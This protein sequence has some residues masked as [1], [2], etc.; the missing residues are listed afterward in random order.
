MQR[1]RPNQHIKTARSVTEESETAFLGWLH[2][3]AKN[4]VQEDTVASRDIGTAITRA[5]CAVSLM[6]LCRG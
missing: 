2:Q 1:S 4:V 5:D 3:I 6:K